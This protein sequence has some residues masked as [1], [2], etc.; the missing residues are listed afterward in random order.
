MQTVDV[1]EI[2]PLLSQWWDEDQEGTEPDEIDLELTPPTGAAQAYTKADMDSDA[3][4][5]GGP[6]DTWIYR[7]PVTLEGAWRYVFD[8][9]IDGEHVIQSGV[10]LAG[11]SSS[12]GPCEPWC[13]W[14]DVAQLCTGLDLSPIADGVRDR[15]L[16]I[17]TDVLYGLDGSRY[18]GLCTT[19]RRLCLGCT[20][21]RREPCACGPTQAVDLGGRW[22]VWAAYDVTIDGEVLDASAYTV[23]DRRWL[24]RLDGTHWP[25]GSD[26]DDPDAFT[27]TWI[28]GRRPPVKLANAAA[29]FAAEMAKSCLGKKCELPQRVTSLTRENVSYVLLDSQNFIDQGRTGVYAVDL[30]LQSAKMGRKTGPGAFAPLTGSHSSRSSP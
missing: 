28:Y 8:A 19:T 15:L 12:P 29:V 23:R 20:V 2:W 5:S 6:L 24:V 7:V 27:A 9:Q 3:S 16:D 14:E 4:Q 1:G 26:L 25:T 17:A 10:F 22:P 11:T 18:P 21:C 13:S 30:A